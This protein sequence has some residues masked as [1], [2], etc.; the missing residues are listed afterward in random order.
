MGKVQ[1]WSNFRPHINFSNSFFAV[2][3][4]YYCPRQCCVVCLSACNE[5][6]TAGLQWRVL[7]KS[8]DAFQRPLKPYVNNSSLREDLHAFLLTQF[9]NIYDSQ[10][11]F[12]LV[13]AEHAAIV[14]VILRLVTQRCCQYGY[15]V[16]RR[17][18]DYYCG[19]VGGMRIGR[20]RPSTV[21]KHWLSAVTWSGIE[22]GPPRRPVINRLRNGTAPDF[23]NQ[24]T[25][26]PNKRNGI[27]KKKKKKKHESTKTATSY[28]REV[29]VESRRVQTG[30]GA[31]PASYSLGTANSFTWG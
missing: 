8:V 3:C 25:Q 17:W 14:S 29:G 9:I 31:L 28:D 2:F 13:K 5:T 30:S 16:L 6:R 10:H 20:G 19:A 27:N 18:W 22:P 21:R 4:A 7:L 11:L 12:S 26:L 23:Q 15:C 24:K 1:K